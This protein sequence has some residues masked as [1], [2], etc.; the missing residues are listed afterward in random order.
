MVSNVKR[1]SEGR[2]LQATNVHARGSSTRVL[3]TRVFDEEIRCR[4]EIFFAQE[5]SKK[6]KK[7]KKNK[8][9]NKVVIDFISFCDDRSC[10]ANGK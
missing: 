1:M 5:L 4:G 3:R 8:N 2:M 6:N 7:N 10:C 9:E